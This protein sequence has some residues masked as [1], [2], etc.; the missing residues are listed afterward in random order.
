M[1]ESILEQKK[2]AF[3][4]AIK[5]YDEFKEK[6]LREDNKFYPFEL[7]SDDYDEWIELQTNIW[8]AKDEYNL[9][10]RSEKKDLN[11]SSKPV[12]DYN[13]KNLFIFHNI[14]WPKFTLVALKED[15]RIK[16]GLSTC[17]NNDNFSRKIGR[18]LAFIRTND[19]R[20]TIPCKESDPLKIRQ[21][22]YELVQDIIDNFDYY[23]QNYI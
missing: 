14:Y 2:E 15:N 20:W 9:L 16:L 21:S 11:I 3:D 10:L 1:K 12:I 23:K 22:L 19:G 4:N 18:E 8:N 17:N 5:T 13:N 6:N 7:F